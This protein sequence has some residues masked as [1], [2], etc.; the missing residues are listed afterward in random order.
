MNICLSHHRQKKN[1]ITLQE[2]RSPRKIDILLI[3]FETLFTALAQAT[4]MKKMITT[5]TR[6][7]IS[8][9]RG[10][11][12]QPALPRKAPKANGNGKSSHD[13]V[14]GDKAWPSRGN[15]WDIRNAS[16]LKAISLKMS[17]KPTGRTGQQLEVHW[18]FRRNTYFL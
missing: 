17:T 6:A 11:I 13:M 10:I 7:F 8:R 15:E 14:L 3:P 16:T 9:Q 4:M 2:A 18:G 1:T 5:T 12:I